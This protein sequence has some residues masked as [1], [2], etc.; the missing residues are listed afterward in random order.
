MKGLAFFQGERIRKLLKYIDEIKK[1]FSR[2]TEP[3]SNKLGT[4]HLW[5]KGIQVSSDEEPINSHKVYNGV[6]SSLNQRYDI[7]ICVY[8]LN[9]FLR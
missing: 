5:V 4:K 2:T 6:F 7:I 9:C 1:F 8:D 3:I